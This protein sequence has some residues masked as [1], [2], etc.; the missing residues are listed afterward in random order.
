MCPAIGWSLGRG[1]RTP[2]STSLADDTARLPFHSTWTPAG[3]ESEIS[4]PRD[5]PAVGA[6]STRSNASSGNALIAA[7]AFTYRGGMFDEL[8]GKLARANLTGLV[9][10]IEYYKLQHGR[11]PGSLEELKPESGRAT[12]F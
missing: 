1:V 10:E 5:R 2:L 4:T 8:R 6:S 9:R 12:R 11:Y 3:R 7:V